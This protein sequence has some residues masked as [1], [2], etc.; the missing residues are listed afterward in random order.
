MW[1]IKNRKKIYV[2]SPGAL[3]ATTADDIFL[4]RPSLDGLAATLWHSLLLIHQSALSMNYET[5]LFPGTFIF[6][7]FPA[8]DAVSSSN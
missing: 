6:P 8:C 4:S 7:K 3:S 2:H 5:G 1:R